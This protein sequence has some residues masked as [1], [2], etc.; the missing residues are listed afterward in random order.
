MNY[1]L[2]SALHFNFYK[3]V[4]RSGLLTHTHQIGFASTDKVDWA[5][6]PGCSDWEVGVVVLGGPSAEIVVGA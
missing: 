5:A 2:R 4:L 6:K 1:S 3:T